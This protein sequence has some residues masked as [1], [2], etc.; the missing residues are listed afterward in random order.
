MS[1]PTTSPTTSESS[2]LP[3]GTEKIGVLLQEPSGSEKQASMVI[4][5][6]TPLE[7][8][9]RARKKTFRIVGTVLGVSLIGLFVHI[10]LPFL[11][12]ADL[13]AL[14]LAVPL[15][16]KLSEEGATFYRVEAA[17][18]HCQAE[19]GLRSYLSTRVAPQMTVQCP[20]C[21]QTSQVRQSS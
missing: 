1:S 10:L 12:L 8:K 15:Y 20:A 18:P 21:G 16:M 14:I 2:Q 11:L 9:K 5:R 3:E 17:C 4:K 7:R 13:I 6:W 19:G